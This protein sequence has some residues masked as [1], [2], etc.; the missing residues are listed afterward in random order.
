LSVNSAEFSVTPLLQS[1]LDIT[2]RYESVTPADVNS[3]DLEL[4]SALEVVF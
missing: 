2:M 1:R 4:R 3:P